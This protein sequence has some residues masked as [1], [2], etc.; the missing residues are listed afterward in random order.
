[1]NRRQ[2]L[3]LF[4]GIGATSGSVPRRAARRGVAEGKAGTMAQMPWP[5]SRSDPD[6]APGTAATSRPHGGLLDAPS[7][8]RRTAG[9]PHRRCSYGGGVQVAAGARLYARSAMRGRRDPDDWSAS[10]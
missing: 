9:L 6:V 3:A 8:G 1:M 4:G 7:M 10:C 2:S 5:Y